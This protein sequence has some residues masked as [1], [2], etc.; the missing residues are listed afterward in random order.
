MFETAK[1]IYNEGGEKAVGDEE[2]TKFFTD[3]YTSYTYFN[4]DLYTTEQTQT[5][6][7]GGALSTNKA[8]PEED[9]KKYEANYKSYADAINSGAKLADVVKDFQKDYELENDPSVSNVEIMD[10]ST[11][12]EDL[13]KAINELKEGQASYKTIGADD[14]KVIYLFYKEPIKNQVKT[15]IEDETNR[16]SVLQSYKGD[17]FKDYIN[18]LAMSLSVEI[19]KAES[20]CNSLIYCTTNEVE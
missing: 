11:I 2:L 10:E 1:F 20:S 17:E 15:Y 7:N 6:E 8:L 4:S 19:S 5:D 9:I 13:V 12:G 3:S 16:N 14:S 18:D